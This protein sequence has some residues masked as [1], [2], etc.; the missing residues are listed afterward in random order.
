[1]TRAFRQRQ[2]GMIISCVCQLLISWSLFS[3][4]KAPAQSHPQN[5]LLQSERAKIICNDSHHSDKK[6]ETS[7][8]LTL[9]Q[10]VTV[11]AFSNLI[12]KVKMRNIDGYDKLINIDQAD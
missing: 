5:R 11:H 7:F 12:D 2:C 8:G 4:F 6:E 10:A 1:M 9:A 3:A